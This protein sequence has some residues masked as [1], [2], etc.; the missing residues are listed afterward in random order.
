VE[1]LKNCII[2][3]GPYGYYMKYKGK[4]NVPLPKKIKDN[5]SSLTSEEGE[6]ILMKFKKKKN[7]ED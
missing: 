2:K 1:G 6:K 7:I 3:N 5:I 4:Y